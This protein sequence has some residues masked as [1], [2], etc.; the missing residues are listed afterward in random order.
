[1]PHTNAVSSVKVISPLNRRSLHISKLWTGWD[2][3]EVVFIL[4][5]EYQTSK[6]LI[7]SFSQ[8][9]KNP[10]WCE[11]KGRKV[12]ISAR[13]GGSAAWQKKLKQKH[14]SKNAVLK[15]R[16]CNLAFLNDCQVFFCLFILQDIDTEGAE[17]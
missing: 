6:T 17:Q 3:L 16:L 14:F 8:T 4:E 9:F 13:K 15:T 12:E 10:V 7:I 5:H 1:M 2:T 11:L